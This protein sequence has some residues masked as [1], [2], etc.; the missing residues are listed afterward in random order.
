ML[1][2]VTNEGILKIITLRVVCH[3]KR[4]IKAYYCSCCMIL[5]KVNLNKLLFVMH[6]T[7]EGVLKIITV[8]AVCH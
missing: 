8:R 5:M 4:S 6:V 3:R 2:Y 7:D 1:L